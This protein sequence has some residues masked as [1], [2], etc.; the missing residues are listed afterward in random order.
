LLQELGLTEAVQASAEK[1]AQASG[2]TL[3]L[4]LAN[5]DGLLPPEFEVNLFRIAQEALNNVLKH[6]GASQVKIALSHEAGALRLVV[7]DDGRGFEPGR[8]ESTP[9]AQ[10]G[11]GV[12]QIYERARMMGGRVDFQSR[13][14]HGARLTVEAPLPTSER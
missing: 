8:L 14:G 4:D 9:P 3:K 6:A 13:P 10:R 11:L 1:A 7:E 2:L 12:R 5:V